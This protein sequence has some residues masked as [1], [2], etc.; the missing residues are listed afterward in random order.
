MNSSRP[1]V[2]GRVTPA[3]MQ[4]NREVFLP[5]SQLPL[6]QFAASVTPGSLNDDHV[7]RA[8]VTDSI[9][10]CTKSREEI[11]DEMTLHLGERVTVRMLNS[12]T[13]GASEKHRWPAQYSRA[14]CHA[15]GDDRLIRCI[16][17]RA[18]L[19]L[20]TSD[21]GKMLELGRQF[22]IRKRAD[23]AI[24][25]LEQILRGAEL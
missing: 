12:Y 11:A 2:G 1:H 14:F 18:G 23:E 17:E 19:H 15:T 21:E 16:T 13:A 8:I 25:K 3:S 9:R 24:A 7:I 20:I 22:L 6:P 4:K 5:D 10:N